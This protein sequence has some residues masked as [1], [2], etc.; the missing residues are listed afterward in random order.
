VTT[1]TR[2]RSH[3]QLK[4]HGIRRLRQEWHETTE[5]EFEVGLDWY[6][7]ANSWVARLAKQ[8]GKTIEQVAAI[9]A[10]LSPR[11]PWHRAIDLTERIL[12]GERTWQ[13]GAQGRAGTSWPRPRHRGEWTEGDLLLPQPHG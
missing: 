12:N 6:D 7:Q 3:A 1:T 10:C 8:H 11:L 9:A 13:A 2:A 5:V 4:R